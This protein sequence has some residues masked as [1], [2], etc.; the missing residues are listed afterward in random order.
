MTGGVNTSM[1]VYWGVNYRGCTSMMGM[2][3]VFI[4]KMNRILS[5]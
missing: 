2:W 4:E 5:E 1:H 3:C